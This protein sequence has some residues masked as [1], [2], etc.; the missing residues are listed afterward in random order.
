MNVHSEREVFFFL[1][2]E[3]NGNDIFRFGYALDWSGLT[4]CA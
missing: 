1:K 4:I 2:H 3:G